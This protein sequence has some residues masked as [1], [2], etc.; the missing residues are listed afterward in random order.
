MPIVSASACGM[1]AATNLTPDL[2]RLSKNAAS[3]DTLTIFGQ[4]DPAPRLERQQ[5]KSITRLLTF[6]YNCS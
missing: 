2:A 1:S 5:K 4:Q 3:R 6:A